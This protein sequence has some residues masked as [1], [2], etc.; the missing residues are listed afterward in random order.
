MFPRSFRYIFAVY[1]W[2]TSI[3][4]RFIDFT[5]FGRKERD[6]FLPISENLAYKEIH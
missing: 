4:F 2:T 1:S 6:M 5:F 3:H